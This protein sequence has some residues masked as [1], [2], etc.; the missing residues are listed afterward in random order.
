MGRS[1]SYRFPLARLEIDADRHATGRALQRGIDV[2]AGASRTKYDRAGPV[3]A[4][5]HAPRWP[6]SESIMDG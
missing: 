5:A 2:N 1:A 3:D 6:A 4:V